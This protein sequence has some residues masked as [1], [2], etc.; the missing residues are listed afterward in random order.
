[1]KAWFD[2]AAALKILW[3]GLLLG[4]GLPALFSVAVR[5]SAAGAGVH[6]DGTTTSRHPALTALAW[7]IYAV[8]L[9]AIVVG[10]LLIARDFIGHHTGWYF[11]GTKSK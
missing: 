7:A 4:A 1:M 6:A 8:V 9:A 11:L 10:V 3:L 5:F 2:Y